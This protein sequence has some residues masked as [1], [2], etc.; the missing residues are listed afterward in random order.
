MI[1][2]LQEMRHEWRIRKLE[3]R[4]RRPREDLIEVYKIA[5]GFP[6]LQLKFQF[7]IN[8]VRKTRGHSYKLIQYHYNKDVR[9][10]FIELGHFEME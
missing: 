1:P 3:E 6:A 9:K 4:R 8:S 7:H 2:G 10:F 5:H